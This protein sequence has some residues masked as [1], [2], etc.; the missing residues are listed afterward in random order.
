MP[1]P[2]DAIGPHP[3]ARLSLSSG[4]DESEG[5]GVVM[6]LIRRLERWWLVRKLHGDCA[7]WDAALRAGYVAPFGACLACA[8]RI[9]RLRMMSFPK[10]KVI[11]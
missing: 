3:V 11:R 1:R 8:P 2:V 9:A 10:A 5:G 7:M 4:R 6:S